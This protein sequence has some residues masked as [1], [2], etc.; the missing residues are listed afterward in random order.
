MVW[1]QELRTWMEFDCLGEMSR[2]KDCRQ[3]LAFRHPAWVQA[4]FRVKTLKM[5]SAQDVQT[6]VTTNSPF[7]GALQMNDQIPPRSLFCSQIIWERF[8]V[9]FFSVHEWPVLYKSCNFIGF[10]EQVVFSP[11]IWPTQTGSIYHLHLKISQNQSA[12]WRTF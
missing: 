12:T 3:W 9:L 7:Q 2:E 8:I 6:S 11:P 1:I 4:I 5:T 10:W